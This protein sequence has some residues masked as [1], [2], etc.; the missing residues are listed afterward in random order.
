MSKINE[1]DLGRYVPASAAFPFNCIL[2]C[3]PGTSGELIKVDDT[4]IIMGN[5]TTCWCIPQGG[6]PCPCCA[7]C[8][9]FGCAFQPPFKVGLIEEHPD[10]YVGTGAIYKCGA[11][12]GCPMMNSV[13]DVVKPLGD[14]KFGYCVLSAPLLPHN[15][16]FLPRWRI[17]NECHDLISARHL[18]RAQTRTSP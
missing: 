16:S 12:A 11:C 6:C 17:P 9:C 4:N 14:G 5:N 10:W 2:L 18:M 3:Q 1:A 15:S 8:G 13:N 7:W